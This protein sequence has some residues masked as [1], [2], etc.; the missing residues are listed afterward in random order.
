MAKKKRRD[1]AQGDFL[2]EVSIDG[3]SLADELERFL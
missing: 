1:P 2:E 3:G